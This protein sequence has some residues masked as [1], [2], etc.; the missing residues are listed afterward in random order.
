MFEIRLSMH[1]ICLSRT[2]G[3]EK[4]RVYIKNSYFYRKISFRLYEAII[5]KNKVRKNLSV[6]DLLIE[7]KE[8][9]GKK[10]LVPLIETSHYQIYQVLLILIIF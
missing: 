9:I 10:V 4:T 3:L 8:Y 1:E 2:T 7:S 6:P 5:V